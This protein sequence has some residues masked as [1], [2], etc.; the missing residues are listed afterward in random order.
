MSQ[1]CEMKINLTFYGITF[2]Q[3]FRVLCYFL[4]AGACWMLAGWSRWGSRPRLDHATR[5]L[6]P[7]AALG[8]T[9]LGHPHAGPSGWNWASNCPGWQVSTQT[10]TDQ[11]IGGKFSIKSFL[12]CHAAKSVI[13][14]QKQC[15]NWLVEGGGPQMVILLIISENLGWK[16]CNLDMDVASAVVI[17][18]VEIFC[19]ISQIQQYFSIV[20]S[21]TD[22]VN[23]QLVWYCIP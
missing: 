5:S 10:P 23:C 7:G 9:A 13:I 20:T 22:T 1:N 4:F 8:P 15:E 18:G 19:V 11:Q 3:F 21:A 14:C 17:S 2:S 16:V 6:T 12:M